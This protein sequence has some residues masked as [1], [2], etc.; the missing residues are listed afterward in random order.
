MSEPQSLK[1]MIEQMCL[2]GMQS[3]MADSDIQ[4]REDARRREETR[5]RWERRQEI[6]DALH[7]PLDDDGRRCVV[8]GEYRETRAMLAVQQALA[9]SRPTR[10]VLLTGGV[11]S[12]KSVGTGKT[13]AAAHALVT[14]GGGMYIESNE[15]ATIGSSRRWEDRER[16]RLAREVECLVVDELGVEERDRRTAR[17]VALFDVINRRQSR[18]R[19]TVLVSNLTTA[20]LT[21]QLDERIRSRMRQSIAIVE[22]TGDDLRKRRP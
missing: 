18:P 22:C 7:V 11:D 3:A 4:A 21:K 15:L 17:D 19:L 16:M 6:L 20:E 14:L 5:A 13:T 2:A 12:S 1:V 9:L 10:F 8:R